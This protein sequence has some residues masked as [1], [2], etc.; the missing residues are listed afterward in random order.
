MPAFAQD[1]NQTDTDTEPEPILEEIEPFAPEVVTGLAFLLYFVG[2][3]IKGFMPFYRKLKAGEIEAF[4]TPYLWVILINVF[5]L[6]GQALEMFPSLP[7]PEV[8]TFAG[9]AGVGFFYMI[10]GAG[11]T[12]AIDEAFK[13]WQFIRPAE[14]KAP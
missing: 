11:L 2:I 7:V 12:W 13:W 10:A 9:L 5:A 14:E 4:G 3:L 1:N 6:L 8:T